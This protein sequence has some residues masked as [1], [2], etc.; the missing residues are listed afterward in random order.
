[1]RV[2]P[3]SLPETSAKVSFL[4]FWVLFEPWTQVSQITDG[5]LICKGLLYLI[6]IRFSDLGDIFTQKEMVQYTEIEF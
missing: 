1:M 5:F 3:V 6:T 4:L 2:E